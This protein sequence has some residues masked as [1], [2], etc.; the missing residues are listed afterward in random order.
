MMSDQDILR[1]HDCIRTEIA[2]SSLKIP[3]IWCDCFADKS[4]NTTSK[5]VWENILIRYITYCGQLKQRT[6]ERRRSDQCRRLVNVSCSWAVNRITESE[7][8]YVSGCKGNQPAD[9][10]LILISRLHGMKR[11]M[12]Y[13]RNST[14]ELRRVS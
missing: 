1:S 6:M 14:L 11:S 12:S 2:L 13:I 7:R 5:Y 10:F 4:T 3:I 9:W 8:D